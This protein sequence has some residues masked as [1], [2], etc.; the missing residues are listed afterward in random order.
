[1]TRHCAWC[2]ERIIRVLAQTMGRHKKSG[3]RWEGTHRTAGDDA[4]EAGRR[5]LKDNTRRAS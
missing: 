2:S 3:G 1:M 4:A 5:G